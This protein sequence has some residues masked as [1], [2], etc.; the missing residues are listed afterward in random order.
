[1]DGGKRLRRCG[2]GGNAL[3]GAALTLIE[4]IG[5]DTAIN[6]APIDVR[7]ERIDVFAALGRGIIQEIGMLPDI[8]DQDRNKPRDIA[9][10]V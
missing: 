4:Q 6:R 2:G 3:G 5:L 7:E 1:M 9:M 10:F 8:H